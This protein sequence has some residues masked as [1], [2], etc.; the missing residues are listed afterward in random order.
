MAEKTVVV[1]GISSFIGGHLARN[2]VQAG[3][4]TVGTISRAVSDYTPL[5]QQ[6]VNYVK[7]AQCTIQQLDITD[8]KACQD[9][10]AQWQPAFWIHHAGYATRY[11]SLD[12][13]MDMG[14]RINVAP[15]EYLF[16]ALKAV[17]CQGVIITGSSAEYGDS[18]QA[19]SE[20]DACY[21]DTPYG[22]SKLA[23][24]IRARQLALQYRLPTRIARVF[25]PFGS[26]DSEQKL[27][28][29]AINHLSNNKT[30]ALSP[31]LQERDFLYIHDLA[32]GYLA[33]I[34]DFTHNSLFDIFNLCSGNPL[35][36]KTFLLSLAGKM[37]CDPN[38]LEFG[39]IPMREGEA[40]V[41][42]GSNKKA[43]SR[44]GWKPHRL[45][46]SISRYLQEILV[47][48]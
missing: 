19:L 44:L 12:Y 6:R 37:M 42:Y 35:K 33:L 7:E 2:I 26:L 17:D 36:L 27:I 23:E 40:L 18:S 43:I 30:I 41:S 32:A 34:E 39:A 47:R 14:Y 1:T 4:Q 15:L 3:Y 45:E 29:S 13:S 22:L 10:I 9:F 20:D 28:P 24:T 38:L 25:I 48:V 11:G 8:A 5:Q 16:P 21:P 31:C 46:D